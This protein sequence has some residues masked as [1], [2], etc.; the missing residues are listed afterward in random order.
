[1]RATTRRCPSGS[2]TS[3]S[4]RRPGRDRAGN[5][6]ARRRLRHGQR[7]P[8]GRA[9]RRARDRDRP[10]AKAARAGRDEG[11]GGRPGD[12]VGGRRRRGAPFEDGS[13]DRVLST[14]GHMFAP[15]HQRVADETMR[16][17][18]KGGAIVTATWTAEESSGRFRP[19][20]PRSCPLL[21]STPRRPSSG[22]ARSTSGR[23]SAGR[24]GVRARATRQLDRGRFGRELCRP[25]HEQVPA[26]GDRAGH[27]RRALRRAPWADRRD[28]A[29]KPTWPTTA[30]SA[31]RRSTC[32]PS[33]ASERPGSCAVDGTPL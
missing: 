21:R 30:A 6:R 14:L 22:E 25:L 2:P 28:L 8:S 26:A 7:R 3:A 18:Q 24:D 13:F 12:R 33:S 1:M 16:V 4:C 29:R 9:G 23:C 20:A 17:C 5:E 19:R 10:G 32:S 11:A 15:R 27:A 31:C